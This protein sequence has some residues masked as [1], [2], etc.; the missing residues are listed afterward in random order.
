M[1]WSYVLGCLFAQVTSHF[2]EIRPRFGASWP[3]TSLVRELPLLCPA[4]FP[5]P[6]SNQCSFP[7]CTLPSSLS[8]G[9]TVVPRPRYRSPITWPAACSL[10]QSALRATIT[11]RLSPKASCSC[12]SSSAQAC[13]LLCHPALPADLPGRICHAVSRPRF[14]LP[15]LYT[16]DQFLQVT[17][18]ASPH[19]HT[20][21]CLACE[22]SSPDCAT[23]R[24]L[25]PSHGSLPS[26][27]LTLFHPACPIP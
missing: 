15:L 4:A 8:V 24:P 19:G 21:C 1:A 6:H 9:H 22:A 2:A 14:W 20:G 13:L 12:A 26:A 23:H 5:P 16:A 7:Q 27:C 3:A 18:S 25:A 11:P 10:P 17:H